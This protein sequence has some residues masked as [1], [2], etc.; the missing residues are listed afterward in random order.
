MEKTSLPIEKTQIFD[1]VSLV[2]NNPL[3][4]LSNIDYQSTII[5]KIKVNFTSQEQ[6]LFVANS[7]GYLNYNSTKDF[8]VKLDNTWKWIGFSQKIRAK[9]LLVNN[10]TENV[11]YIF[12][13]DNSGAKTTNKKEEKL[14]E[15]FL[16]QEKKL[17]VGGRPNENI[18]LTIRCFKKLCLKAKTKKADEIHEY[19]L[20]L[21]DLMNEVV[22]EQTEKLKNQLL[23]KDKELQL[24]DNQIKN[25][26]IDVM[27]KNQQDLLFKHAK[28]RGIYIIMIPDRKAKFG[29]CNDI[30][31][32][33]KDHK[34]DISNDIILVYFLE[35][36][37]NGVIEKKIKDL[38]KDE[39][40]ILFGKRINKE[41]KHLSATG[42]E[43]VKNQTELIQ[44]DEMFTI[45]QFWNKV[46]QIEKNINKD[47]LFIQMEHTIEILESK[48]GGY[49]E[50]IE[51][52]NEK[53]R[54]VSKLHLIDE[55]IYPLIAVEI[56]TKKV[57]TFEN[58]AKARYFYKSDVTTLRHY[59]DRK[60]QLKG[61]YLRSSK[62][63]PY[64]VPP[65]NFKYNECIKQTI[66]NVYIKRVDKITNEIVYYNSITEAS[67]YLQQ[68]L[69]NDCTKVLKGET[70]ESILLKK[71]IGEL[72]RGLP[73]KKQI[74]NKYK[75]IKMKEIGFMYNPVDDSKIDISEEMDLEKN[76]ETNETN[77][78][79]D[80][81]KRKDVIIIR[82]LLTGTEQ[83]YQEGYSSTRL[84]TDYG[85]KRD[86]FD[87]YLDIFDN[88]KNLTIRTLNSPIWN[89]P[90]NYI[91]YKENNSSKVDY[92]IKVENLLSKEVYYYHSINDTA[93]H[94]FPEID[95]E[96]ARR[97]IHKKLANKN[98]ALLKDYTFTKLK[99]CGTVLH[100]DG[101]V[102][103][104]EEV[105]TEN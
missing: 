53:I 26:D 10:F 69:D 74:I 39:D 47:E 92:Y 16:S 24:K 96:T 104:I 68:E 9:E 103:N 42:D 94:I 51:E 33:F 59:I 14:D 4:K 34:R 78:T 77:E 57:H 73:T 66:Q 6:L 86:V 99:K 72:L 40:D 55:L 38:C 58:L 61:T 23:M 64:W 60:K 50:K 71:A 98:P 30:V 48:L 83:I 102:E 82:N 12:G 35:T 17:N 15:G 36:V 100:N 11:D 89:P 88:Y 45:E 43:V 20:K 84:Y 75:W 70:R 65:K 63:Q 25:K 54:Q 93:I 80:K 101:S 5:E 19:Y 18:L 3:I 31:V 91:I 97:T 76:D 41:Y 49:Q 21:E 105:F 1:I 22:Y 85:I 79:E 29:I 46:L 8:V 13:P 52:K 62:K 67:L 44:L 32:R 87:K 95:P 90:K 7:Y 37:Y 28:K 81:I 56:D 27:F 2:E